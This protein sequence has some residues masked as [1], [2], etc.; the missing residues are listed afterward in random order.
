MSQVLIPVLEI[1]F[2]L[3]GFYKNDSPIWGLSVKN[4]KQID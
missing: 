2:L 4:L 3:F 1:S